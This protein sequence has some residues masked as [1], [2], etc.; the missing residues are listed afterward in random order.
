MNTKPIPESTQKRWDEMS[1]LEKTM[2]V[3]EVVKNFYAN[4]VPDKPTV[5]P[6]ILTPAKV[7]QVYAS[8]DERSGSI[9][10]YYLD[11]GQALE[12][13]KNCGWYDSSG[14]VSELLFAYTDGANFYIAKGIKVTDVEALKAQAKQMR[15]DQI[16]AK[17][18]PEEI[19]LLGLGQAQM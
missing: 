15:I 16:K 3:T 10:G 9:H 12:F 19:E 18:T 14:K 8:D 2:S 7:Y 1:E 13:A 5:E 11:Y 6:L 4:V 17:L